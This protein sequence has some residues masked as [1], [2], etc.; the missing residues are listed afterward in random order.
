[1]ILVVAEQRDGKLNRASWEAIAGAQ[2]MGAPVKVVVPGANLSTLAAELASADVAEVIALEDAALAEYTADG[3]VLALSAL[4][5]AEAPTHVVFAH[6]YQ[7]RDFAPRLAAR[8]D[9]AIVTDC[10]SVKID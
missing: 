5:A 4:V 10:V 6:T 7:A 2:Q 3:Y 9:R 8:L 1:M